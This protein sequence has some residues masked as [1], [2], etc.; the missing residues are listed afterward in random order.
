LIGKCSCVIGSIVLHGA[1]EHD[2]G[3]GHPEGARHFVVERDLGT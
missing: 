3:F 2:Q 1:V